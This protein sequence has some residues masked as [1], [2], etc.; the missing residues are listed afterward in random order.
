MDQ[1]GLAGRVAVVT[2][3]SRARGIGAAVCRALAAAGADV[4]FTF[5]QPYDRTMAWGADEGFPQEL[6]DELRAIGVRAEGLAVDLAD[7]EAPA[8]L[9]TTAEERLGPVA[10]L[11][12]NATY[13]TNDSFERLDAG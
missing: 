13:S 6:A 7:A 12:N 1:R 11:V 3:A 2:G 5:W 9:L 10:I 4:C 8:R